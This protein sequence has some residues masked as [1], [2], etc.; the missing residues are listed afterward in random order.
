MSRSDRP[1]SAAVA[2]VFDAPGII[3]AARAEDQA[4]PPRVRSTSATGLAPKL[5]RFWDRAIITTHR[6]FF[7]RSS[8]LNLGFCR[9]LFFLLILWLLARYNTTS[10]WAEI[11]PVY[12]KPVW[13]FQKLHF[14]QPS[15]RTA[16]ALLAVWRVTLALAC[17][18]F[19][20]RFSIA[21]SMM[22]GIY[23]LG[24]AQNFG[25]SAHGEAVLVLMM[26]V[27]MLSRCGDAFSID[28]LLAARRGK[29]APRKSGE[30]TWPI[31]M[32]WILLSLVFFSAGLTKLKRSGLEWIT[33]DHMAIILLSHNYALRNPPTRLGLWIA[34]RAWRCHVLAALSLLTEVGFPLALTHRYLRA[35][36]V[37]S[38]L[39]MQ[40]GI[41][42]TLGIWF[43]TFLC[44]YLF[45]VPWDRVASVAG[46]MVARF[47]PPGLR[48][49]HR[50]PLARRSQARAPAA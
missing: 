33:S 17:V 30:Y 6:F 10:V 32:A 36:F 13:L 47:A 15:P 27:L 23:L 43:S 3:A 26:G 19:F 14:Q 16:A 4:L 35:W 31:K 9:F 50:L 20:T 44:M 40:A 18:G 48:L 25:K 24:L 7:T 22:L 2:A 39:M 28:A 49:S 38:G 11:P 34:K 21:A 5:A 45:F 46:S 42:L 8:P 12:W 37:I 1:A 41:A 29:P